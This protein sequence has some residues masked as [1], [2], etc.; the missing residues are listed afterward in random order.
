MPTTTGSTASR[1]DGLEARLT[2]MAWPLPAVK[3]PEAPLWYFTSPEPW[4]DSGSRLPFELLED[5]PV[6]LAHDVGQDVEPAAVGHAHHRLGQAL[7]HRLVEDG[8]EEDD[9][10][11]RPLEAE[12]LLAHV[13]GVEEALED[14]GGVEPVE[15]VA[16]LLGGE[17]GGHALHVLLDPPLLLGVLDVHV[18]DAQ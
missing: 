4:T 17:G 1:C 18:L 3:V 12:A 13:A 5:L 14:L 16:L 7:P 10:R 9:G 6:R 11:L 15:D 8:V 2:G